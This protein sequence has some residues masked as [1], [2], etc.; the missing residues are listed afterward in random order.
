VVGTSRHITQGLI[1]L[2][3]EQWRGGELS[4]VSKVVAGDPY[5]LRIVP[6]NWAA[7]SAEHATILDK[8]SPLRVKVDSSL[9]GEVHWK[10]KFRVGQ[11][12]SL[13]PIGNRPTTS[14][15]KTPPA[16]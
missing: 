10:V 12:D 6:G 9:S 5:E 16:S 7:V 8:G 4:G 2:S 15:S 3:N 11:A 1:D 13:R 14:G